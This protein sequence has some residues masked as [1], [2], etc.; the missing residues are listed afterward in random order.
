MTSARKVSTNRQN[1][2]ASTGPKSKTGK[3]RS[4]RNALKHGLA[5]GVLDRQT[6]ERVDQLAAV[7]ASASGPSDPAQALDLAEAQVGLLQV[8]A[9]RRLLLHESA[10]L[11]V[12]GSH[13]G[14]SG[15]SSATPAADERS[16]RA[17]FDAIT[18]RLERL[19]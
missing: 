9:V 15:A 5:R 2:Q 17:Q 7:L 14:S 18:Q 12:V 13:S 8:R 4:S 16:R 19:D 3:A 1:A 6:A 11:L 10:E